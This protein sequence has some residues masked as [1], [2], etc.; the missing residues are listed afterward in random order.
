M[1][2]DGDWSDLFSVVWESLAPS[3]LTTWR[4]LPEAAE[5]GAY[6]VAALLVEKL[7]DLAVVARSAKGT[8][9]DYWLGGIGETDSLFQKRVRLEV[10]GILADGTRI[11]SRTMAKMRQTDR[12]ARSFPAIIVVVDFSTP[13][14]RVVRQ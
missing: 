6:G 5:H 1:K 2:V 3:A 14:S 13:R 10:S 12:S 11:G 4:D 7:A 9:F 8:G